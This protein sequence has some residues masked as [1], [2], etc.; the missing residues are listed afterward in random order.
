MT[1]TPADRATQLRWIAGLLVAPT[2]V[3]TFVVAKR[4]NTDLS[5]DQTR[6]LVVMFSI[7]VVVAL[8]IVIWATNGPSPP[9]LATAAGRIEARVLLSEARDSVGVAYVE[10]LTEST[11]ELARTLNP[12]YHQSIQGRVDECRNK[13]A[14]RVE[15][16][17]PSKRFRVAVIVLLIL[18][19][20][21]LAVTVWLL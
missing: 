4:S 21:E 14:D 20:A 16:V 12:D 11:E 9:D 15:A 1:S 13:V 19:G 8:L 10:Q 2:Q 17:R 6:L 18:L 7:V 3:V 5:V